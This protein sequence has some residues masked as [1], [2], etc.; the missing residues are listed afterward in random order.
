MFP[1]LSG[2]YFRSR[3][4]A[5]VGLQVLLIS[6]WVTHLL[7]TWERRTELEMGT[8]I[9][10]TAFFRVNVLFLVVAAAAIAAKGW[11]SR[12]NTTR[13]MLYVFGLCMALPPL[14]MLLLAQG[15]TNLL[16]VDRYISNTTVPAALMAG[17][18]IARVRWQAAVPGWAFWVGLTSLF[19]FWTFA[20]TG[21][22]SGV[23][24]EDWRGTVAQVESELD[25]KP[26]EVVLLRTFLEGDLLPRGREVPSVL[27]APLRSPGREMPDWKLVHLTYTWDLAG[28]DQFFEDVVVPAVEDDDS[29]Y[30]VG[31]DGGLSRSSV[32]YDQRLIEWIQRRFEGRFRV[33][34]MKT[35]T[36]MIVLRFSA[37]P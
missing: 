7:S 9:D 6:P 28:R 16:T 29:F 13:S 18:L 23:G 11:P 26:G 19:F 5:D 33:E 1:V 27:K 10:H 31:C 3:F 17:I 14:M 12:D 2:K 25:R 37:G 36:G 24:A 15:G 4:F 21:S 32:Q 22:F 35:G 30:Y 34:R 8:E 20:R